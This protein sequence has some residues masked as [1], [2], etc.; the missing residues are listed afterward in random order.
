MGGGLLV[1]VLACGNTRAAEEGFTSL[2]NGKDLSGWQYLGK[3]LDGKTATPD[4][5][6][7][8]KDGIII[9]NARDAQGKGGIK[10]LYTIKTYNKDFHLKVEF[11]ASLKADSG[12]YLRGKQLQVRDY[13]RRGEQKQLTKFKDD[14]WNELDIVV[15]GG[16]ATCLCNGE[17]LAPKTMTVPKKS[18]K[19][20]GLQAETGKFEFRNVRIKEE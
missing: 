11:R 17:A 9:M 13:R 6:I 7:E 1:L 20:I 3:P 2:F 10:D 18:G 14:D 15:K 5:R 4:G 8:V 19:G 16:T 12:V